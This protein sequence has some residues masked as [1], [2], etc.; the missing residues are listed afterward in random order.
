[1]VGTPIS[2]HVAVNLG[3]ELGL[4]DRLT[5]D[6]GGHLRLGHA[7]LACRHKDEDESYDNLFGKHL[8]ASLKVT[9]IGL[10]HPANEARTIP[11]WPEWGQG[12]V[13]CPN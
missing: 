10:G 9:L 1:M 4:G 3:L 13:D 12:M 11:S 7:C 2:L 8:A 6:L 5:V